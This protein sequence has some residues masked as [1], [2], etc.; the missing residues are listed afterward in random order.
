MQNKII[1][2]KLME[3]SL[4]MIEREGLILP[5]V[6]LYNAFYDHYNP[7]TSNLL[8]NARKNNSNAAYIY[9]LL[10]WYSSATANLC[11]D[12]AERYYTNINEYAFFRI[13]MY[14]DDRS[15][16]HLPEGTVQ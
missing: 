6:T 15:T 13:F 11:L 16:L 2:R 10:F 5:T 9:S 4:D 8:N 12:F 7:E 14:G 3:L 1:M